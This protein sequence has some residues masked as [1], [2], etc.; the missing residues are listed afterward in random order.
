[1]KKRNNK[2]Q[3]SGNLLVRIGKYLDRTIGT[4]KFAVI[5]ILLFALAS[6]YGTFMESYHG[7]EF[8]SKLVY[9]SWWFMGMQF[10]MFAS[11]LT[12]TLSRL[13]LKKR[14]YGFYTL[15]AG[16]LI[17][18]IGSFFTYVTGID[19]MLELMPNQPNNRVLLEQDRFVVSYPDGTIKSFPL[20][21]SA[22]PS[23]VDYEEPG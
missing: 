4:M 1:M 20:P 3:P 13:P 5:I 8:A 7:R 22:F 14:L 17:L 21:T 16:L 19:G 6:T 12:A 18:F 11:I 10:L 2:S 23:S 15:H 9:K